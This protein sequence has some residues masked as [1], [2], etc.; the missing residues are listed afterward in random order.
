MTQ[1]DAIIQND[2]LQRFLTTLGGVETDKTDAEA[3]V[4]CRED[5]WYSEITDAA[6]ATV[7]NQTLDAAAF[8]HYEADGGLELGMN[9]DKLHDFVSTADGDTLVELSYNAERRKLEVDIGTADF[10][11]ALIQPDSIRNAKDVS[12]MDIIDGMVADVTVESAALDHGIDVTA[13]VSNHVT[14]YADPDR[15][16]PVHFVAEGDI[17]D[18]TVRY[19]ES[20]QEGSTVDGEAESIYSLDY[21]E[22]LSAVMPDDADVRLRF[23]DEWPLRFDYGYADGNAEVIIMLAPRIES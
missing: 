18:M 15:E 21:L 11:M 8:E 23:G 9:L 12:E 14:F 13:M 2:T 22:S 4:T 5:G 3:V 20:L 6:T 17:D 16:S 10:T 1:F 7:V 19:G